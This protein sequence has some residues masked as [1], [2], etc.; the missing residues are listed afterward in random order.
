MKR[1]WNEVQDGAADG[2]YKAYDIEDR[3]LV[4]HRIGRFYVVEK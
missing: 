3:S 2:G 1:W 4:W